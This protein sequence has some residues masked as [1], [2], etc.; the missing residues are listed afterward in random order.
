M[1]N[2][3]LIL[4]CGALSATIFSVGMTMALKQG[5]VLGC[6]YAYRDLYTKYDIKHIDEDSL[7][8]FCEKQ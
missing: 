5:K 1:K 4:I 7:K 6:Q 8:S 2:G 3:L